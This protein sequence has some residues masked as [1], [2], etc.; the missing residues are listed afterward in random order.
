LFNTALPSG[1]CALI[2]QVHMKN[3]ICFE[4]FQWILSC[5]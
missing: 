2:H 5:T 1:Y 3:I 4:S